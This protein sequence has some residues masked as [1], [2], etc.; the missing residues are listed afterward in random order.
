MVRIGNNTLYSS[1]VKAIF[2]V[3]YLCII[4]IFLRGGSISVEMEIPPMLFSMTILTY[5]LLVDYRVRSKSLLKCITSIGLFIL[6]IQII[7]Q[8]FPTSAVFG[9]NNPD[10]VPSYSDVADIRNN[11][12]RFLLQTYQLSLVCMFYW[13]NKFLN[14]KTPISLFLFICFAVSVYLYLTRQI[15][16]SSII[17]LF[18]TPFLAKT[19]NKS[20]KLITFFIVVVFTLIAPTLLGELIDM[21]K[22]GGDSSDN[23]LLSYVFF[24]KKILAT[25]SSFFFGNGTPPESD[26]WHELELNA[27]DIG[28]VGEIYHKGIFVLVVYMIIIYK[29]LIKNKDKTPLYVRLYV[30]CTFINSIMIFPYLQGFEYFLWAILLYLSEDSQLYKADAPTFKRQYSLTNLK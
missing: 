30:I 21:T 2:G 6:L 15:I 16:F 29:L 1:V 20:V 27:S 12:Y 3:S 23:R 7:Q 5:F 24:G 8:L 11:L 10:K 19:S 22:D 28:V 9:I 25:P 17:V 4:T 26:Y 13:W 18:L 14:N